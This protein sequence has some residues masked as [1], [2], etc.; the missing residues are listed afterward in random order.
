MSV[1]INVF[2]QYYFSFLKKIKDIAREIKHKYL[3][4]NPEANYS[5][6]LK[7]IKSHYASYDTTSE[8]YYER[9]VNI[10][11]EL[12]K[13]WLNNE[14]KTI[15][16]F[17]SWFKDVTNLETEIYQDMSLDLINSIM[18]DDKKTVLY[19]NVIIF[20]IFSQKLNDDQT[21]LIIECI[22]NITSND[23]DYTKGLEKIESE[24]IRTSLQMLRLVHNDTV[25]NSVESSLKKLE[26]TSL[27]KLAKEIMSDINLDE[28]QSMFKEDDMLKSLANPDGGLQ[29]LLGSV[30][31]KMISKLASGEI[32]QE[33]LLQ[34]AIQFSSQIKNIIPS[35]SGGNGG[36]DGIPGGTQMNEMFEQLQKLTGGMGGGGGGG[37]GGLGALGNLQQMMEA[38]NLGGEDDNNG[39]RRGFNIGKGGAG[40][41]GKNTKTRLDSNEMNRKIKIKQLRNKLDAKKAAKENM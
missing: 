11:S 19:Y 27:G 20:F 23:E 38:F 39:N 24:Y 4:K 25:K 31:Q 21:A 36:S 34:D 41:G 29:K 10:S 3:A 13:S 16:E 35:G 12:Y 37:G 2:N 22:K 40:G 28:M 1:H 6:I 26:E 14:I 15:E 9:F 18:P 7:S 5:K 30:S 32:K 17:E 33:T 8:Q